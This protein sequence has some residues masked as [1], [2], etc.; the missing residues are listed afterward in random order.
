MRGEWTGEQDAERK[1]RWGSEKV[2]EEGKREGE[3]IGGGGGVYTVTP[4]CGP[5]RGGK[6]I[7]FRVI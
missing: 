5:K 1:A 2:G 3:A 7:H 4:S 6:N